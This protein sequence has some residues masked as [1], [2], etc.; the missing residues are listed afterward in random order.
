METAT[1]TLPPTFSKHAHAQNEPTIVCIFWSKSINSEG[2]KVVFRRR[3]VEHSPPSDRMSERE[4][5]E[6]K[7]PGVFRR[8]APHPAAGMCFECGFCSDVGTAAPSL[9]REPRHPEC[10]ASPWK[11]HLQT[12]GVSVVATMRHILSTSE[13]VDTSEREAAA[14]LGVQPFRLQ[15]RSA[16][17]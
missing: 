10:T 7:V 12:T 6:R 13:D 3:E 1:C 16:L 5:T 14:K 4:E 15:M 17:S 11:H 9:C 2:C 8:V